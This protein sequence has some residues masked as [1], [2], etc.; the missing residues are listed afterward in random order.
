MSLAVDRVRAH[1]ASDLLRRIDDITTDSLHRHA[2]AAP[3]EIAERISALDR[4]WDTDRVLETEAAMMGW[5]V[6]HWARSYG[7][8]CWRCQRWWLQACLSRDARDRARALCDQGAA[9]R[10]R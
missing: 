8:S 1:I 6:W 5:R 7:R 10:L 3:G 4:E 9:R 2:Q